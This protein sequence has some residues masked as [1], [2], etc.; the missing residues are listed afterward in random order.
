MIFQQNFNRFPPKVKN[1]QDVIGPHYPPNV[2]DYKRFHEEALAKLWTKEGLV[3]L[4]KQYGHLPHIGGFLSQQ[5]K[6]KNLTIQ[7]PFKTL[8]K[9]IISCLKQIQI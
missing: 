9:R 7:R 2:P 4:E 5:S 1:N 6:E 3:G 8:S